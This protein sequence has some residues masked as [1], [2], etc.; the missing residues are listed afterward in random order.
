M[1]AA[2]GSRVIDADP[3]FAD[4]AL[5]AIEAQARGALEDLDHVLGLLRDPT[6]TAPQPTLDDLDALLTTT[7][8]A[9]VAVTA[10]VTGDLARLPRALSRETYRIIQECLTNAVRHAGR[11]PVGIRLAVTERALELDVTN[12]LTRRAGVWRAGGG[13]GLDGIRERVALLRG[14]MSAAADDGSWR[15]RVRVPLEEA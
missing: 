1:Q 11:V 10:E 4:R 13:R 12:Q 9:D 8:S 2:A 5:R 6:T 14:E 7:R 3:A 15:V